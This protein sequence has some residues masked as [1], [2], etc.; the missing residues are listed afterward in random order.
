MDPAVAFYS[1]KNNS[2]HEH[3]HLLV[4]VIAITLIPRSRDLV[5]SDVY[6]VVGCGFECKQDG[7]PARPLFVTL[8]HAFSM[9]RH[10]SANGSVVRKVNGAPASSEVFEDESFRGFVRKDLRLQNQTIYESEFYLAVLLGRFFGPEP[11][12]ALVGGSPK[13]D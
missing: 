4:S 2:R 13:Q 3:L 7:H 1:L 8:G 9:E 10:I 6:V 12:S 11:F 5:V